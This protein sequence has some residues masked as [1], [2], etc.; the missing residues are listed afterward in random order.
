MTFGIVIPTYKREK[1]ITRA[2]N[3]VLEQTY[4][5]FIICVVNDCSPDNTQEVLKTYSDN[6]K[7]HT[8]LLEKN[9]GVNTARNSALNYLIEK[10]DYIVFLDD[11]DYF[12]NDTLKTAL[13]IISKE[14]SKWLLFNRITPEGKK[15]THVEKY[16][17]NDYF[18][19]YLTSFSITGD[20]VMFIDTCLL[21]GI[22]FEE[23]INAREYLFFLQ[24]W[25]TKQAPMYVYNFNAT[26]CEYL[27]EGLSNSSK[28]ETKEEKKYI[29]NIERSILQKANVS[30]YELNILT[31]QMQLIKFFKNNNLKKVIRYTRKIFSLNSK[32]IIQQFF[33]K[34]IK[35]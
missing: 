18:Y 10:V 7:V 35:N 1:L 20:A 15:I 8:I 11:D 28:K 6:D 31:Y 19:D 17:Y 25:A 29:R 5:N 26:I 21:K 33:F 2:I 3:S 23:S 16:G 34:T 22:R 12:I 30:L 9:S 4:Q 14:H 13:Q 32:Q 27:D 24:I